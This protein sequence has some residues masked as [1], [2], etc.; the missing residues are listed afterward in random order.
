VDLGLAGKSALVVGGGGG[1]GGAIA[2]ALGREGARVAVADVREDA[3]QAVAGDIARAGGAASALAL[4]IGDVAS[5]PE[6]VSA[7]AADQGDVEILVNLTGGPPPTPASGNDPEL[8]SKHFQSM[9][10]GVIRLTDLV[11]PAMRSNGWGR[12]I[13]STS[14]GVIAPIPNLG[15]SNALRMSLVGWSKTLAGEVGPDGVTVNIVLPGRIATGRITQL[16]E[17]RAGREGKTVQEVA[18]ASSASIPLRR[19]GDPD[20]YGAAVA[21]LASTAASYVT[22][23]T[24]RVDGGLIPST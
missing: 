21:F 19:Y 10:L 18:A 8:W 1:L 5:L 7:V 22:G 2:R 23:T 6:K 14:S 9:V 16:D 12:V 13:T 20:E 24:L 3:A 11:L 4:D 17:A 15:M